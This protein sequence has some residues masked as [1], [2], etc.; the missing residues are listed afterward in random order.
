MMTLVLMVRRLSAFVFSLNL[1]KKALLKN[2]P[3]REK[4]QQEE[5]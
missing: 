4:G 2:L 3:K 5:G 1:A